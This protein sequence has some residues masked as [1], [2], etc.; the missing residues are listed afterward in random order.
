MSNSSYV[1]Q[2]SNFFKISI[3]HSP[4]ACFRAQSQE[5]DWQEFLKSLEKK[6]K[7]T[8]II[9]QAKHKKDSGDDSFRLDDDDDDE[10]LE[11]GSTSRPYLPRTAKNDA[12]GHLRESSG[13]D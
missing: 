2:S 10:I 11:G 7:N 12:D 8:K 1:F 9:K 6:E 13:T 3:L 5:P 4:E